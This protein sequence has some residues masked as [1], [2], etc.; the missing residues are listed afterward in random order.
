MYSKLINKLPESRV[1]DEIVN[2]AVKIEIEFVVNAL[3]VV[4]IGMN[5]GMMCNVIRFCAD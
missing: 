2:S 5:S 4:L 1:V 3:P